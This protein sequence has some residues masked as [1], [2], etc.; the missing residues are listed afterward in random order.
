MNHYLGTLLYL[1]GHLKNPSG[2]VTS[3]LLRVQRMDRFARRSWFCPTPLPSGALTQG[4]LD[5]NSG[6]SRPLL[7]FWRAA[8]LAVTIAIGVGCVLGGQRI[9]HARER[10]EWA[11][12]LQARELAI[13]QLT[14]EGQ[15]MHAVLAAH[16]A[17]ETRPQVLPAAW[18][19]PP[20]KPVKTKL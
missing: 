8:L 1:N 16:K 6:P 19:A 14:R 7:R 5:F 18:T 11:R 15:M 2:V 3:P 17:A 4:R 9:E 20:V 12:Q 13:H 10:L